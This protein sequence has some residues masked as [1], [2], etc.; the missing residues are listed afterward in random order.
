MGCKRILLSNDYYP[1]LSRP[2]VD[3]V[4]SGLQ[5]VRGSTLVA[6]DGTTH[7]VDTVVFATGFHVTDMPI[8]N[9]IYDGAGRSLA[10]HWRDGMS[11]LRGTT[12][13]G[14]PNFFLIVGPNTGLGHSSM[15]YMI[16]SQ[17]NYILSAL[18]HL[19]STGS[20]ALEPRRSAQDAW[21]ARLQRDAA[22]M[23][24]RGGCAAGTSMPGC[25]TTL[26]PGSTSASARRHPP[27][28]PRE[29]HLFRPAPHCTVRPD[30]TGGSVR[31]PD[32][33]R[34][35]RPTRV[36][37]VLRR[38]HHAAREVHGPEDA[39]TVVFSHG[40]TCSTLV[41]LPASCHRR[42]H[43]AV[44]TTSA[45]TARN[46]RRGL[47]HHGSCRRPGAVLHATVPAAPGRRR[48]PQHGRHDPGRSGPARIRP[49]GSCSPAPAATTGPRPPVGGPLSPL[50]LPPDAATARC[51]SGRSPR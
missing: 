27:D 8:A 3:V 19:D 45:G 18:R 51:R 6:A 21:N 11:A 10:D 41:W 23:W 39:P 30:C 1:A 22:R 46:P 24:A 4:A 9:R 32:T 49:G 44:P 16:E 31:L 38:R 40:W 12:V 48:R 28:R 42:Q 20:A 47:Q 5:E 14:F 26:W 35:P 33:L 29:Y 2:N 17:L 15:I 13:T 7:D 25:N 36:L 34:P 37:R 43:R 50:R